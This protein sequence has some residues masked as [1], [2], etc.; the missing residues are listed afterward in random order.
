MADLTLLDSLVV[1]EVEELSALRS[2]EVAVL[3]EVPEVADVVLPEVVLPDVELPEPADDEL[4]ELP[5]VELLDVG[6]GV[7]VV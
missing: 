7:G 1:E 2:L 6:V 3:V 4:L 5:E